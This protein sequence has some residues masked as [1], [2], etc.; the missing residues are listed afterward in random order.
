MMT[1]KNELWLN[2]P[3]LG[4]YQRVTRE[5]NPVAW[6][7]AHG[8]DLGGNLDQAHAEARAEALDAEFEDRSRERMERRKDWHYDVPK[9]HWRTATGFSVFI[10]S[11]NDGYLDNCIRFAETKR[12]H[13][14][15]YWILI[16]ERNSRK[17][18]K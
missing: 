3:L 17:E 15:R 2:L 11:M 16:A 13:A 9:T 5:S 1:T 14:S 12:Q 7:Y 4:G 8:S 6:A 18:K 10:T